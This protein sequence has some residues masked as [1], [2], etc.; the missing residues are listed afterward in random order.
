MVDILSPSYGIVNQF[1]QA[2]GLKPVF[3]LGDN[4]VFPFTMVVT[5]VWKNFGFNTIV[6][7]ASLTG[8]NPE[9]YESAII[10]GA[11]RWKQTWHITRPVCFRLSSTSV[12]SLGNVLNAGFDQIFIMYSPQVYRSGD[13]ID[14][15]VYRVGFVNA[16]Y[17]VS[18]A[19]GLFKSLVSFVMIVISYRLADKLANYKIF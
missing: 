7:L 8:I 15:M 17:S 2:V 3:F 11:G 13:I 1:I 16:Q 5:D 10:D 9:L 4:R 19:L 6:Y 14:T 12:L 18:A